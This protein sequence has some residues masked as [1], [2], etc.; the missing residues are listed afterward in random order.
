M[1]TKLLIS[2]HKRAKVFSDT[3]LTPIHLGRALAC[4]QPELHEDAGNNDFMW[5]CENMLG[6]DTGDNISTKNPLYNELTAIYWAWKNFD[7]LG[8]PDFI[9]FMHYRRHFVFKKNNKSYFQTAK[10]DTDYLEKLNYSKQNI[11]NILSSC[12]FVTNTP[13]QRTSVY[14]HYKNAHNISELDTVLQII[15]ENYPDYNDAA[16]TYIFGN[17]AYFY[18]MFIFPKDIFFR[19]A[20]WMFDI[21]FKFEKTISV[22]RMFVS[23]RL[24]GIFFTKLLFEGL[25]QTCLPTMFITDAK[26]KFKVAVNQ[27]KENLKY[28]TQKKLGFKNRVYALRPLILFFLPSFVVR[29]YRNRKA[30]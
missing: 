1:K 5:M 23:E 6:D 27:T 26:P 19:Y 15:D 2:Y 20:N 11:E 29:A 4:R 18:N 28:A 13:H 25:T 8:N 9:G 12:D 21:L 16:K 24:T 10:I 3:I 14:N 30:K 22:E 17:K 7:K